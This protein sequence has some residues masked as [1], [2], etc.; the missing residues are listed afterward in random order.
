MTP[1]APIA[2]LLLALLALMACKDVCWE[3][4]SM[5]GSLNIEYVAKLI[6]KEGTR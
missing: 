5:L 6:R 4:S 1:E 2:L 3:V